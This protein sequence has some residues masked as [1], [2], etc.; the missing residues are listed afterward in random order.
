[1]AELVRALLA[2]CSVSK[3]LLLRLRVCL[4]KGWCSMTVMFVMEPRW[5]QGVSLHFAVGITVSR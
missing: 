3:V 2:D 1:M 5:Y 4:C